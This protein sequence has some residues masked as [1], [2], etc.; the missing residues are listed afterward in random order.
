VAA[1][2]DGQPAIFYSSAVGNF[3]GYVARS[4]ASGWNVNTTPP[5]LAAA[6]L[7]FDGNGELQLLGDEG[8]LVVDYLHGSGQSWSTPEVVT[9]NYVGAHTLVADSAGCLYATA[10][11]TDN[12]KLIVGQRQ[13]GVWSWGWLD[14]AHAYGYEYPALALGSDGRLQT[15]YRAGDTSSISLWWSQPPSAPEQV[16]QMPGGFGGG[17]LRLGTAGTTPHILFYDGQALQY[18][19]RAGGAWTTTEVERDQGDSSGFCSTPMDGAQCTQ[20]MIQHVPLGVLTSDGGDVR[21]IYAASDTTIV[22]QWSC[23]NRFSP[24]LGAPPPQC[25]LVQVSETSTGTIS[26]AWPENFSISHAVVKDN[27]GAISG[28]AIADV[29]GTIHVALYVP[30]NP[31]NYSTVRYLSFTP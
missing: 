30:D 22:S 25:G 6:S 23:P 18:A 3:I 7:T 17:A 19:T 10:L 13:G 5:A 1:G 12:E 8:N 24:D 14:S 20:H 27:I 9:P 29:K 2:G 11:Y 4:G 28:T 31:D 26:V 21:L 16:T 15:T